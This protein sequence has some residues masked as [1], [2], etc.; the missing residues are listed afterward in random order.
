MTSPQR[1]VAPVAREEEQTLETTLRPRRLSDD[2]YINQEKVKANLRILI[3]A[4][5]GRN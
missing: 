4:A 3:D 2:E 5:K 1:P